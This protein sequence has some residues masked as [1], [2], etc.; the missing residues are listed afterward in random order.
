MPEIARGDS[1]SF[2]RRS[3]DV[4]TSDPQDVYVTYSNEQ[5]SATSSRV[6]RRSRQPTVSPEHRSQLR[7]LWVKAKRHANAISKAIAV[8]PSHS[9]GP[10][11]EL[12]VV[13]EQMWGLRKAASDDNWV[14]IL[15]ALQSVLT[16]LGGDG[17]AL[18][19]LEQAN[20]LEAYIED[21][22]SLS[23]KS[24]ESLVEASRRM[25]DF[26]VPPFLD[27]KAAYEENR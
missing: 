22:L 24:E 13:L 23:T 5:S 12:G 10:A 17:V 27:Y 2:S 6:T 16:Q 19:S 25:K 21:L 8:D 9:F 4:E 26:G 14:G 15:D 7:S 11:C 1:A 20:K 3:R 18:L